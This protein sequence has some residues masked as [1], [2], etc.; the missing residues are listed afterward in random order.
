M[1]IMFQY[2]LYSNNLTSD[3]NMNQNKEEVIMT[4]DI[5]GRNLHTNSNGIGYYIFKNGKV[6]KRLFNKEYK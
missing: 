6:E 3:I 2:L 5:L 4:I 1:N